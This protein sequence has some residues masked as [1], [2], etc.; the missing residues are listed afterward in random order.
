MG[1]RLQEVHIAALVLIGGIGEQEPRVK[2]R[3]QLQLRQ[4]DLVYS[5]EY[6]SW[7]SK[8]GRSESS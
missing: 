3:C 2:C 4:Q 7:A 8:A 5:E 6:L 1:Q